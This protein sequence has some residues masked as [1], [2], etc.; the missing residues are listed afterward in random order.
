MTPNA[1]ASIY[2]GKNLA[3]H[4]VAREWHEEADIT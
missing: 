1:I 2:G 4:K 3:A